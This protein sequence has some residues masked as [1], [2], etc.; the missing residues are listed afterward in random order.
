MSNIITN[1][2]LT[3]SIVSATSIQTEKRYYQQGESIGV[4][5]S[6]LPG[7]RD[8]WLGLFFSICSIFRLD[9]I[10]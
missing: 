8:D 6:G 5:V 1:I 10:V 9:R 7:N 3:V 4:L 2:L